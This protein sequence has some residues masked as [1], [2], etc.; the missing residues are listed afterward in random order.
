[1]GSGEGE[2]IRNRLIELSGRLDRLI[3]EGERMAGEFKNIRE[4]IKDE[5]VMFTLLEGFD[6]A[7]KA[8]NELCEKL[9]GSRENIGRKLDLLENSVF[10][11]CLIVLSRAIGLWYKKKAIVLIKERETIVRRLMTDLGLLGFWVGSCIRWSREANPPIRPLHDLLME[12]IATFAD[13]LVEALMFEEKQ[14]E[15]GLLGLG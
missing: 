11:Q 9:R 1:M 10:E 6:G 14:R 5:G 7:E 3:E 12:V 8:V 4:S 2:A 15:K 13:N